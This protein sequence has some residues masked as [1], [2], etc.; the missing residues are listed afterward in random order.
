MISSIRATIREF[1]APDHRISCPRKLWVRLARELW[2]RGEEVHEAGAFLLGNERKGRLVVHEIL[3]YDD[4]DPH[5]YDSGV[6][7][8]QSDAFA[9]LWRMCRARRL[10]VVADVHTHP[11]A[12]T[13]STSDRKSVV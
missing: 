3:F 8:L 2:L 5:A 11:G 6:C 1:V 9:A 13:Q 7:I 10:T 4:L 12:A